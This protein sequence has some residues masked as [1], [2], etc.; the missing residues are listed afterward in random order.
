MAPLIKDAMKTSA[1]ISRKTREEALRAKRDD[2][3]GKKRGGDNKL[4]ST[5]GKS[6]EQPETETEDKVSSHPRAFGDKHGGAPKEF[7]TTST[8]APRRLNDIA[9][10]P[11]ELTKLPRETRDGGGSRGGQTRV[12]VGEGIVREGVSMAQRMMME[13]E[14]EKAIERYRD[15][16]KRHDI[17]SI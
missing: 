4:K 8:S 9:L 2:K 6:P 13:V 10:A 3:A 1:S 14:R 5:T 11:P 16:K 17:T 7:Q 15:M 12:G